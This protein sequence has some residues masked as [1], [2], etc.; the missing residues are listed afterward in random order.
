MNDVSLLAIQAKD[1][2]ALMCPLWDAVRRLVVL[3]ANKYIAEGGN[4]GT[5]L[6]EADDLIQAGYLALV[7]AV[8]T[9]DADKGELTTLLRYHVLNRFSEVSGRRGRKLRPE[10]YAASLDAPLSTDS[11]TTRADMIADTAADFTD[12]IIEREAIRQDCAAII[13]E[14]QKLPDAQRQALLLTAWDGLTLKEAAQVMAVKSPD[15][16]RQLR[17]KAAYRVR[18]TRAGELIANDY[19]IRRVGLSEFQRTGISEVEWAVFR[20]EGL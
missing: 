11:D 4:A 6:Y 9:Y 7:D 16:V 19:Q 17:K 15:Y 10:V 13:A 18:R 20:A 3:W 1:N 14:M 8:D 12:D 2:P 5:R